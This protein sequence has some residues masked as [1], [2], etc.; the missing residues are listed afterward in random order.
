MLKMD[1][2]LHRLSAQSSVQRVVW[3]E[4]TSLSN[5]TDP[6]FIIGLLSVFSASSFLLI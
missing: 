1:L 3:D 4:L 5:T 2:N 6:K